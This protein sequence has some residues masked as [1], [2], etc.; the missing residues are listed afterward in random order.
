[1]KAESTAAPPPQRGESGSRE[2]A[3]G[4]GSTS[5][6][7]ARGHGRVA[8]GC[9]VLLAGDGV[10]ELEVDEAALLQLLHQLH[11]V[12]LRQ[13]HARPRALRRLQLPLQ[14]QELRVHLLCRCDAWRRR[15]RRG[16]RRRFAEID[17]WR[18][19]GSGDS[20]CGREN[21]GS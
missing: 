17:R 6:R 1:M 21:E 8:Y 20:T 7:D 4:L 3:R 19:W 13:P 11:H 15:R 10:E 18:G 2:T 9:D 16:R 14:L 5:S 12:P